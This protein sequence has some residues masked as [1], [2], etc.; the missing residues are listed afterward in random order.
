LAKNK[1]RKPEG[2]TGR[3]V[4]ACRL[5]PLRFARSGGGKEKGERDGSS[6]P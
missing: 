6:L 5:T 4:V 2:A 3:G 1:G